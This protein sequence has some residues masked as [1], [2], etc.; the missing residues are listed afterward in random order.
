MISPL[1]SPFR[2]GFRNLTP[3]RGRGRGG[4]AWSPANLAPTVWYDA[5]LG[6]SSTQITDSSGNGRDALVFAAS[7]AAPTYLPAA[8]PFYVYMPAA[9]GNTISTP[10]SA[11]FG[12]TGDQD[13]R[14][15]G[16]VADWTPAANV[17]L[18]SQDSGGAGGRRF[19]FSLNSSGRLTLIWSADATAA[20]TKSATV[21]LPFTDA[22]PGCVRAT[23]DVDNGAAGND[24]KFYW[25]NGTTYAEL[26]DNTGWTLLDTVTTAS[27]TSVSAT[28]TAAVRVAGS[29]ALAAAT[30]FTHT[31]AS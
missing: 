30:S 31:T 1:A 10:D 15:C 20:I 22:T 29:S 9:S 12:F 27:T 21:A 25:K 14:W 3:M 19:T 13:V 5:H 17:A 6:G 18:M 11:A 24:V 23:L 2:G 16:T 7:T 8:Q 26:T 28:S 4:V